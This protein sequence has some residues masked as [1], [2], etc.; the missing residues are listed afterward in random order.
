MKRL[1]MLALASLT[2]LAAAQEI[3]P[4]NPEPPAQPPALT[5]AQPVPAPPSDNQF[6]SLS[7]VSATLSA[8]LTL[9]GKATLVLSLKSTLDTPVNLLARR[10]NRQDC[11]FAPMIRVIQVGTR[12]VV[13]PSGGGKVKLCAQDMSTET[14]KAGGT[15]RYTRTVEL[16]AGEYMIEGWFQGFAGDLPVKIPAQPVRVTVK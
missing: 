4:I 15:L 2:V 6:Q 1:F 16:P 13:Y 14:L 11:A 5:P 9:M 12:E 8:P 7:G 3:L 10:D